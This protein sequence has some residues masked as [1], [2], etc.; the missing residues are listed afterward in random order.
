M[1]HGANP[2]LRDAAGKVALH[3]C[4]EHG[5]VLTAK[6]LVEF[7]TEA[8]F[9]SPDLCRR[10]PLHSTLYAMLRFKAGSAMG[11]LLMHNLDKIVELLLPCSDLKLADS[12]GNT[13]LKLERQ[14]R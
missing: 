6:Q 3:Y 1:E 13:I 5:H 2:T 9:I 14:A 4:A 11:T 8:Q 10:T 12:Y 7:G